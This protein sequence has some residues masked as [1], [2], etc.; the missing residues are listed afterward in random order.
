MK[1]CLERGKILWYT[2]GDDYDSL[3]WRGAEFWNE[4][5][6]LNLILKKYSPRKD[7]YEDIEPRL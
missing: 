7:I 2:S 6:G 5:G 1:F 4:I 3:T